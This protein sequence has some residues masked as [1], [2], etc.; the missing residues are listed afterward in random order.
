MQLE[1]DRF[2]RRL[3]REWRRR[4]PSDF[5]PSFDDDEGGSYRLRSRTPSSEFFS[6]DEDHYYTRGS[7]NLFR[8]GLGNDAM[9]RALNQIFKSSF[10][11]RLLYEQI[12]V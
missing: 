7:K 2:R 5:D 12:T 8:E 3:C 4:T 10:K 1:I 6:Y 11:C 9:S